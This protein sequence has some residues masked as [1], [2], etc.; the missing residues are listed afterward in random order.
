M[1]VIAHSAAAT[2]LRNAVK[3]DSRFDIR[4]FNV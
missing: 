2:R 1:V 4:Q 3:D